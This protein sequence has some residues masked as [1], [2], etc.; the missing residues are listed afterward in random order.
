MA[1][2]N[3]FWKAYPHCRRPPRSKKAVCRGLFKMISTTGRKTTCEGIPLDLRATPE[4]LV[5]A[6]KAY[7]AEIDGDGFTRVQ[8]EAREYVPGAQVW[9]NQGCYEDFVDMN[10]DVDEMPTPEQRG[11][12]E[13]V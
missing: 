6:A 5:V 8:H 7:A 12:F 2:F 13:V 4:Q 1:T 3:E 11:R 9:L 10:D